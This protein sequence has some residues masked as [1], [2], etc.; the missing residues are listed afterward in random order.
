MGE[1]RG[2]NAKQQRFAEE[3]IVDL[4]ATQAAKRA[5][6]SEK[7]AHTIGHDLLKKPEIEAAIQAAKCARSARTEITAD[8]V[9]SELSRLG[10]SDV[11][12]LFTETGQLRN[13]TDL[14]DATAAAIASIE[15]VTKPGAD[16][17]EDGNRTVEYVHKF[18][19]WDKN[20]ALDKIAKHLGM[21]VEKH[22]HTG[23]NGKDLIPPTDPLEVARRIAFALRQGIEAKE[24]DAG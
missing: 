3:Y 22:E 16:V 23:A 4:N 10:F 12:R 21:L 14:D 11:R 13:V 9:L 18:K 19:L 6:Y 7:T 24:S 17:D 20:S 5:G 15:V 2:L 1:K 8:R